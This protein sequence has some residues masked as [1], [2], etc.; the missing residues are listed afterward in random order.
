MYFGKNKLQTSYM[1]VQVILLY[2]NIVQN[3]LRHINIFSILFKF[4]IN[5]T[6]ICDIQSLTLS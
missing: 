1:Y 5:A 4:R 6:D 2:T 3:K